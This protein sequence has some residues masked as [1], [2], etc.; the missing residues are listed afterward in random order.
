[1]LL[2][3]PLLVP[4]SF[5]WPIE[6][7]KDPYDHFQFDLT[8][9][10][11]NRD[12]AEYNLVIEWWEWDLLTWNPLVNWGDEKVTKTKFVRARAG[13]YSFSMDGAMDGDEPWSRGYAVY[14]EI[15]HDCEQHGRTTN[16]ELKINNRCTVEQKLCHYRI[17]YDITDKSGSEWINANGLREGPYI[18]FPDFKPDLIK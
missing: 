18:P 14:A 1:M 15:T 17:I 11:R 13:T 8:F 6:T 12:R 9:I 7:P 16:L 4:I 2:L 5:G 10:C 3:L